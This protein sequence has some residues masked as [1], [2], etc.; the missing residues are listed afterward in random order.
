V[1]PT[2]IF[3]GTFTGNEISDKIFS[4]EI[5]YFN[6]TKSSKIFCE[7]IYNIL[8]YSFHFAEVEKAEFS[9]SRE[10]HF[11]NL[12]SARKSILEYSN[13]ENLI[14]PLLNDL[15]LDFN[16]FYIDFPRLRAITTYGH[17]MEAA[18]PAYYIHRDTWYAN[19]ESQWNLWIPLTKVDSSNSFIFFPEFFNKKVK[20]DSDKFSY[21]HWQKEGGFQSISVKKNF[22]TNTEIISTEKTF[23]VELDKSEILIFSASHL[24]GTMCNTSDKTRF[25]IDLRITP[26]INYK[27]KKGAPNVDNFSS[28][29]S[30]VDFWKNT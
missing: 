9:I 23:A 18:K 28:G 24:H 7:T 4:G 22:P 29:D 21:D 14:F 27:Q 26:K 17:T 1:S 19:S 16:D 5:F 2:L 25:S 8:Q 6:A 30:I 15:G 3:P 11:K 10:S 20:N 12:Q 13:L